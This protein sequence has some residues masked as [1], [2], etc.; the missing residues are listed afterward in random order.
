MSPRTQ[1]PLLIGC[2]VAAA[3]VVL[4]LLGGAFV[5]MTHP[6]IPLIY[7]IPFVMIGFAVAAAVFIWSAVRQSQR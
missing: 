5:R 7:I 2:L 1:K 4:T 3:I 6:R